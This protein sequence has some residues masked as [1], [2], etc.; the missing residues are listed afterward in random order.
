VLPD[1]NVY[2]VV[3]GLWRS[4]NSFHSPTRATLYIMLYPLLVGGVGASATVELHW[5]RKYHVRASA[6]APRARFGNDVACQNSYGRACATVGL[7]SGILD[8][9]RRIQDSSLAVGQWRCCARLRRPLQ[10]IGLMISSPV[11]CRC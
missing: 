6:F 7:S 2:G 1:G 3:E 10:L 5:P 4:S 9:R 11:K 8:R